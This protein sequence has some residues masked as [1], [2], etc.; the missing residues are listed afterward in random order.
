[1]TP[2]RMAA[3]SC[4]TTALA[5]YTIGTFKEQRGHRATPG[6]RGFLTAGVAF[7]VTATTLM[8]LATRRQG[9]TL[10]GV[11]GYSALAAMFVDTVLIWRHWRR[12]GDADVPRGLHLYARVAYA[13][14]VVAYFT[15]AALVMADRAVTGQASP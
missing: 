9:V 12:S 4:V 11:L 5:L 2:L 15:G 6:V 7:D 3:V 14:W 1:M 13:Y 10:H 8:I